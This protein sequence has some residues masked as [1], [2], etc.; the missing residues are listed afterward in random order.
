MEASPICEAAPLATRASSLWHDL[1]LLVLLIALTTGLRVWHLWHTEVAARD[2]IGYIRYAWQLQHQ[3]WV[4]V[5][6]HGDQHPGYPAA[7]VAMSLVVRQVVSGPDSVIMQLSA[8]LASS[9]AAVL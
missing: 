7:I 8:Q 5:V 9:V 3:P 6:S 1:R 4:E 2:S